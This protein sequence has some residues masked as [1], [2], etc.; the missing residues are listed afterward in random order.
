MSYATLDN[1]IDR[2]GRDLLLQITDRA[3]PPAEDIDADV[4]ARALLD[5]DEF[6]NGFLGRY[7]TP[8]AEVP[9]LLTD[10]AQV[11]AIYKLH[12]YQPDP[13]I[14]EDYKDALRALRDIAS[15]AIR[16]AVSETGAEPEAAK[17]TGIR[18][19]DRVR[20]LTAENLKGFI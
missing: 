5:T 3:D 20:P 19:S 18:V 15:G 7:K 17:V 1:L 16:L 2:F 6:I 14:V 8:L 11:I 13:K 12:R 10:L 4:V 9:G